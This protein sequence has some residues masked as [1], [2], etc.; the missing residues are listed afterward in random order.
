MAATSNLRGLAEFATESAM[1]HMRKC[2]LVYGLNE[3][4]F[5]FEIERSRDDATVYQA[6]D[7]LSVPVSELLGVHCIPACGVYGDAYEPLVPLVLLSL[8]LIA[9]RGHKLSYPQ[10]PASVNR[11]MD[12]SRF[13]HV[14]FVVVVLPQLVR[15][16]CQHF[17]CDSTDEF[18]VVYHL[19]SI[20]DA[21]TAVFT[22]VSRQTAILC[23]AFELHGVDSAH[24][25]AVQTSSELK[26]L[27]S[28]LPRA[29]GATAAPNTGSGTHDS[30]PSADGKMP[31]DSGVPS[32]KATEPSNAKHSRD[33]LGI[34]VNSLDWR[35]V[36]IHNQRFSPC[37]NQ[38]RLL[39]QL[40]DGSPCM[41]HSFWLVGATHDSSIPTTA[42]SPPATNASS[43]QASSAG[44]TGVFPAPPSLDDATVAVIPGSRCVISYHVIAGTPQME[45]LLAQSAAGSQTI[46]ELL[47]C[48]TQS[49][50]SELSAVA[51]TVW[52]CLPPVTTPSA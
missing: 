12:F 1:G 25:P 45:A 32:L 23:G 21:S 15:G 34:P 3:K 11:T 9:S 47:L 18:N 28:I 29:H 30:L 6:R 10:L 17:T 27:D 2:S 50:N 49:G 41:L 16:V 37:N 13:E 8:P 33:G 14:D 26:V 4:A 35:A 31:A 42:A 5:Q 39:D 22:G 51:Q 19:W 20:P 43:F 36:V 38:L 44:T 40:E 24:L 46:G 48:W 7:V 52:S